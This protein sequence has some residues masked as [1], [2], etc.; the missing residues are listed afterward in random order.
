M[1]LGINNTLA[2]PQIQGLGVPVSYFNLVL[3]LTE[4]EFKP[5][6]P[7]FIIILSFVVNG[8]TYSFSQAFN[9]SDINQ[10]NQITIGNI[11]VL[12]QYLGDEA[13]TNLKVSIA[14]MGNVTG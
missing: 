1:Q 9:T 8:M 7:Q 13:L 2:I 10:D 4:L 6:S 5:L 12:G 14:Y 3:D 11:I